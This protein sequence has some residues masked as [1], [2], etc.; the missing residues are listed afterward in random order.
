MSVD[1][2]DEQAARKKAASIYSKKTLSIYDYLVLGISNKF[3][4][5]CSTELLL[6][7]YNEYISSNHLDVGVGTGYF[8]DKCTFPTEKP[9]LHL[10]DLNPNSL[11]AAAKRVNRYQPVKHQGDILEPIKLPQIFDSISINYLLHCLPGD[12]ADK[13][14]VF[15]HLLANLNPEGGVLFGSTILGA[16]IKRNYI[17]K[18]I[19]HLYNSRGI[20]N[21]SQDTLPQLKLILENN[22][23]TYTLKTVGCV[24]LFAGK[25]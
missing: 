9:T 3:A 13:E 17:A 20:F 1:V 6:D 12:M 4:W 22:F 2:T 16:G 15:K 18:K 19:M 10:L 5:K 8:L 7:F 14:K 21:N 25:V 24:A 23:N 11:E